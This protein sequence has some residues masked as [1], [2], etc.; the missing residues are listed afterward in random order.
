MAAVPEG[1]GGKTALIVGSA[2]GVWEEVEAARKLFTPDY[3]IAV[4]HAMIDYPDAYDFGASYH[5]EQFRYWMQRRAA[6]GFGPPAAIFTCERRRMPK[7]LDQELDIRIVPNWAGSSGLIAVTAATLELQCR[8]IVLCGVHLSK[9]SGHYHDPGQPK[10]WRD[11]LVY[12]RSWIARKA[13]LR[14]IVR[15]MGGWTRAEFGEPTAEWFDV[16]RSEA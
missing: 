10:E 5:S 16:R 2:R 8:A 4:N 6:K 14:D 15:S 3:V 11:A 7:G 9:E 12:R 13:E 1:M